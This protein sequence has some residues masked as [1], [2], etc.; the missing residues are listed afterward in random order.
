MK[1]L[2]FVFG[3]LVIFKLPAQNEGSL[4][5][6][7]KLGIEDANV[8]IK[9]YVKP[10]SDILIFEMGQPSISFTLEKKFSL[11][12][13]TW[14]LVTPT[15][16]RTYDVESLNLQ[17]VEPKDQNNRFAQT[18][19]GDTLSVRL[20]SKKKDLFGNPAFSFDTPEGS[21][22]PLIPMPY[23]NIDFQAERNTGLSLGF[24]PYVEL[25]VVE[26][27][28]MMIKSGVRQNVLKWFSFL[29]RDRF[30]WNIYVNY[31][32]F[33]GYKKLDVQPGLINLNA[34]LINNQSGPYDNQRLQI[35]YHA[36]SLASGLVYKMKHTGVFVNFGIN[37]GFSQIKLL[38]NYPVYQADPSGIFSVTASDITDPID[39]MDNHF[40]FFN[41]TG[42]YW[43]GEHWF[44]TVQGELG[45]YSG[46]SFGLGYQL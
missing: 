10:A 21:G 40:Q 16:F 29:N 20:V 45:K 4:G 28:I 8:L 1:K 30:D 23:L 22:Y 5:E 42:F 25:P 15:R 24:I 9:A 2:F 34:H 37:G 36:L 18:L 26:L 39:L 31:G 35:F 19:T 33:Y 11:S 38:G 7:V 14:G 46:G 6:Y 3:L 12:V 43:K 17:T 44:F 13:Q 27:K 32:F 41:Q